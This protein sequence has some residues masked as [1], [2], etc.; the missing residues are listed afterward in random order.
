[1]QIIL[2]LLHSLTQIN[3]CNRVLL[4]RPLIE[5]LQGSILSCAK[6]IR[7]HT[8][9]LPDKAVGYLGEFMALLPLLGVTVFKE[10]LENCQ[11]SI[12]VVTEVPWKLG[13]WLPDLFPRFVY[14]FYLKAVS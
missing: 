11:D 6:Q 12:P 4:V 8:S 7:M 10:E 1:M 3:G 14:K 2:W 9:Y 5:C 13:T